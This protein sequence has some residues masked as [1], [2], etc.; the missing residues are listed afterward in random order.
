VLDDDHENTMFTLCNIG[1][2]LY[3][4]G[5]YSEAL[6]YD[7]EVVERRTRVLGPDH[8]DTLISLKH[9]AFTLK[10]LERKEEALQLFKI[11]LE[12]SCRVFG[13]NHPDS[14]STQRQIKRLE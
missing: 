11:V 12:R 8:K 4:L 13:E 5:R 2:A 10:K 7:N 9:K 1:V 3:K 14:K 6:T